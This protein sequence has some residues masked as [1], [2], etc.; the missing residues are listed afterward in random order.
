MSVT[1]AKDGTCEYKEAPD[2]DYPVKMKLAE[3]DTSAIFV[4]AGKLD[5]FSRALESPLKVAKM[6]MK[7][8]RFEDGDK[9]TQVQFNFSEDLD[10]RAIQDWFE[11]ISETAQHFLTMERTVKYEKLGVNQAILKFEAALE[12]N[13]L[14]DLELFLPLLDRVAKNS[15]YLNMART[16][17]AT[18][19]ETIRAGK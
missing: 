17:A 6:G 12:R 2:D 8:F 3:G 14:V 16:R 9:K 13:R 19:A 10:A 1:L 18:L 11:R 4:I 7:T 5:H 15:S